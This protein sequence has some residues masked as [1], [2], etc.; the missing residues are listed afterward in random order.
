MKKQLVALKLSNAR[1]FEKSALR[2]SRFVRVL[3]CAG[4]SRPL[5]C[6]LRVVH[7]VGVRRWL[8]GP[9]ER[10]ERKSR[11]ASA[12]TDGPDGPAFSHAALPSNTSTAYQGSEGRKHMQHDDKAPR[13]Q[14]YAL[15]GIRPVVRSHACWSDD[16]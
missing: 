14:P 1:I 11:D 4:A 3:G 5:V 15:L 7:V 13:A 16:G 10:A 9:A 12:P 6:V 2:G 8:W